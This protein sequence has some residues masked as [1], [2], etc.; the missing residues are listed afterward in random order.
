MG[1]KKRTK[2][3]TRASSSS[4]SSRLSFDNAPI[5]VLYRASSPPLPSPPSPP[6]PVMAPKRRSARL[7]RQS[8]IAPPHQSV[9]EVDQV[10]PGPSG[11]GSSSSSSSR[12]VYEVIEPIVHHH[13]QQAPLSPPPPNEMQRVRSRSNENG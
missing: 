3:S 10:M 5:N 11:L 7:M 1:A 9:A 8:L 2:S 4:S 12:Q 13:H 6:P